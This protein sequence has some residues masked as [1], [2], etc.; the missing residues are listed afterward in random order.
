MVIVSIRAVHGIQTTWSGVFST[1]LY[2]HR[3]QEVHTDDPTPYHY[4][5]MTGINKMK[6]FRIRCRKQMSDRWAF[7]WLP[8]KAENQTGQCASTDANKDC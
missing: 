2:G 3:K 5:P 4:A 1:I 7:Q 8:A 6:P